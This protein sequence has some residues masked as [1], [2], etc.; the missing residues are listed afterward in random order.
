MIGWQ[1]RRKTGTA[2]N[3]VIKIKKLTSEYAK[4]YPVAG[5]YTE[6]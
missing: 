1:A 2:G 6:Q 3:A 5:L 4:N